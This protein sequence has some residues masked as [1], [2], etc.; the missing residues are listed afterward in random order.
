MKKT[1]VF[2]M[3]LL[4]VV[5]M[6]GCF[7][8]QGNAAPS[9]VRQINPD[10]EAANKEKVPVTLYFGYKDEFLLAGEPRVI[11]APV[12]GRLETAV[13]KELIKG[14][15]P[16]NQNLTALTDPAL[17][18]ESVAENGDFLFVTLNKVFLDS[19]RDR[20]TDAG[21]KKQ[22]LEVCAIVNTMAELGGYSR[23]QIFVDT[24]GSGLG[25]RIKMADAGFDNAGDALL[26]PLSFNSAIV[27]NPK[28]TAAEFLK[29]YANKDYERM[30]DFIA[31]YDQN[32]EERPLEEDFLSGVVSF[33]SGIEDYSATD[34]FMSADGASCVALINF[35]VSKTNGTSQKMKDIPLILIKEDNIWRISYNS[36]K[37]VFRF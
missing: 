3:I 26:E 34:Y 5:P 9:E 28:N 24:D 20:E 2:F 25:Q 36:F 33:N 27:L 32:K 29:S 8:Q 19:F 37:K 22:Q 31:A 23:V 14:P 4:L 30:Y 7:L 1:I 12:N 6:L 18:V 13:L 15:S 16:E 21:R 35:S 17:T 10:E 11:D